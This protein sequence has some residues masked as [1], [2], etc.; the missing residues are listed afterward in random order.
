MAFTGG[1]MG[2]RGACK[3]KNGYITRELGERAADRMAA[4][5]AY[6]PGLQVKRCGYKACQLW[7]VSHKIGK[8]R[9]GRR[10]S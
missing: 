10:W 5:G 4:R 2:R 6:R 8:D 3:T 9:K 1:G 7:H